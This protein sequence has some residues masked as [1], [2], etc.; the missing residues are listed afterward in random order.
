MSG[1]ATG[2]GMAI[3]SA[4]SL[5]EIDL[6]EGLGDEALKA[7]ARTM[8]SIHAEV[9]KVIISEGDH[10]Q[11]MFVVI[12][13]ELEVFKKSRSGSDLRVA[14]LGPGD[15]FGDMSIVDPHPRSASVRAIA[16]TMLLRMSAEQLDDSFFENDLKTYALLMRNV[17]RELSRR[18]RVADGIL[19]QMVVNV[20]ETYRPP[21][22]TRK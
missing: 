18:L 1:G 12:Q 8:P 2:R 3:V 5:K 10:H 6:F 11:E 19:S 9:G 7:L 4:A 14:L 15:W 13:G 20:S 22:A 21:P 16:P 17:A